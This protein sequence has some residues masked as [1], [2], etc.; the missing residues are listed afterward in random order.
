MEDAE[1]QGD[2]ANQQTKMILISFTHFRIN[3]IVFSLNIVIRKL[4]G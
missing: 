4:R 3:S 1:T 2:P